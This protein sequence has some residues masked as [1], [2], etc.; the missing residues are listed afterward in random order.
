[1]VIAI[2]QKFQVLQ[3]AQVKQN[4]QTGKV[5]VLDEKQQDCKDGL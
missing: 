1:M 3:E 5:P 4:I 2:F